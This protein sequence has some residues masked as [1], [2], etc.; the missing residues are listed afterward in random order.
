MLILDK[1][2]AIERMMALTAEH[3][4]GT[5]GPADDAA[6]VRRRQRVATF[7]RRATPLRNVSGERRTL[8][9]APSPAPQPG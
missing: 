3:E 6:H 4:T 5:D 2:R 7:E 1:H 9:G 8:P